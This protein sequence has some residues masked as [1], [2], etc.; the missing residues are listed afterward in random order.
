[1]S[2]ITSRKASKSLTAFKN[3]VLLNHIIQTGCGIHSPS[4]LFHNLF[5][6]PTMTNLSVSQLNTSLPAVRRLDGRLNFIFNEKFIFSVFSRFYL[7]FYFLF[8]PI[9]YCLFTF[10]SYSLFVVL[11]FFR[12]ILFSFSFNLFLFYFRFVLTSFSFYVFL[13]YYENKIFSFNEFLE[14]I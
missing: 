10:F 6:F 11:S 2:F 4:N 3:F 1:M 5:I 8:T 14:V 7:F 12:F 13:S 9:F